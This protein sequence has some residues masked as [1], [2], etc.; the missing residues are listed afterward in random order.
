MHVKFF[1]TEFQLHCNLFIAAR[2]ILHR[3][4]CFL[5]TLKNTLTN[6]LVNLVI[7]S[8]KSWQCEDICIGALFI[9]WTAAF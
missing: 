6:M 7:F 5:Q 1:G 4:H 2:L 9:S 3:S 8:H